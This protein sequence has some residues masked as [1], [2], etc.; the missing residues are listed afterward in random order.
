MDDKVSALVYVNKRNNQVITCDLEG[1]ILDVKNFDSIFDLERVDF[2]NGQLRFVAKQPNSVVLLDKTLNTI[3]SVPSYDNRSWH[4]FN[5]YYGKISLLAVDASN[6]SHMVGNLS[7]PSNRIH[8]YDEKGAKYGEES[9]LGD[10]PDNIAS[11]SHFTLNGKEYLFVG[12]WD[13]SRLFSPDLRTKLDILHPH[14]SHPADASNNVGRIYALTKRADHEEKHHPADFLKVYDSSLEQIAQKSIGEIGKDEVRSVKCVDFAD[15]SYLLLG[16]QNEGM[17]VYSH[18]F[19]KVASVDRTVFWKVK[20]AEIK[21]EDYLFVPSNRGIVVRDKDMNLKGVLDASYLPVCPYTISLDGKDY[22]VGATK[23]GQAS[24]YEADFRR[25]IVVDDSVFTFGNEDQP[26]NEGV[27]K[28]R[29]V[30]TKEGDLLAVECISQEGISLYK[31][32]DKDVTRVLA[33]TGGDMNFI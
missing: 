10:A 23:R 12:G 13:N 16:L 3:F 1:K 19:K 4:L 11:I 9:G 8:F 33:V 20:K 6:T 28:M 26:W 25:N 32:K 5:P 21:G 2:K 31:V 30:P 22:L 14:N 27:W 7:I 29:S 18:D 17:V 24:L 15:T